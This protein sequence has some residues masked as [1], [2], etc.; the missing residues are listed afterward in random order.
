M[1]R[2][3]PPAT[4]RC[5]RLEITHRARTTRQQ[6][7]IGVDYRIL[8][9]RALRIVF[10]EPGVCSFFWRIRMPVI[11]LWLK[12]WI[13]QGPRLRCVVNVEASAPK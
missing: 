5:P 11:I 4:P 2:F 3:S 12:G 1:E 6:A 10:G 13:A 8:E 9:R 7:A